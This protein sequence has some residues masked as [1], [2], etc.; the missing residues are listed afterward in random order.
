[1]ASAGAFGSPT[2]LERSG[3][4]SKEVLHKNGIS[5]IVDLPGVGDHYMDHLVAFIHYHGSEE[6]D[7]IDNVLRGDEAD[8][9]EA[10]WLKDGTGLLSHIG[11]DAISKLRPTDAERQAMSP[12]FDHRWETFFAN[13]PDKPVAALCTSA[14]GI[15]A[16]P[17]LPIGTYF[18]IGAIMSY[19]LATG[20]VHITGGLD[21]HGNLDFHP[22]YMDELADLVTFRWAYKRNRELARRM[23]FYRGEVLSSH[24]RFSKGSAAEI[25]SSALPVATTAP[26]I[27][28]TKEDDEA[29]DR[30]NREIASTAWHSCGTCAMKP[31]D[32]GG[33]VDERLNV[34]GV[35]NLKVA[36]ISIFPENVG[37]N[38]YNSAIAIGEKAAVIIAQDLGIKGVTEF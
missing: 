24:P 33:V 4:G 11:F 15:G 23:K 22:G 27:V 12:E 6:T 7:C 35:Q 10:Q 34:Y 37:S 3:I 13:Y 1:V 36:D 19:P 28:Y 18:G 2:I 30:F 16:S 29:I 38:T 26:D 25:Q 5:Q 20:R 8:A 17:D 14:S 32:K 21:P 9:H 31:R